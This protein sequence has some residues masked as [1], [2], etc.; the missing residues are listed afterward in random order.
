MEGRETLSARDVAGIR[1]RLETSFVGRC[2]GAFVVMQGVDRAMAIAAQAFTALIP[3][4]LL[5][6]ALA[7][8]DS[9]DIVSD[10]IIRR[11]ALG[12]AAAS[13]VR[14]LFAHAPDTGTGV[15]SVVLLVFSGVSLTRRIQGM[16]L[17]AWRL[18]ASG[19]LRTSANALLGLA[20]LM[21]EIALLYLARSLL[22][23]LPVDGLLGLPVSLLAGLFLWTSVPWLLLDRR[24]V[25][26]RLLP[27]GALAGL[28]SSI[29]GAASTISMP[30]LMESYSERFGLFGVTLALVGWLLS[31]ALIV[32]AATVV[33]A[34]FDRAPEPWAS[35]LR[36]RM[37]VESLD[38]SPADKGE[39]RQAG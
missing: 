21:V 4:L 19:G 17:R 1:R 8:T 34:E 10:A 16:Y 38:H 39:G 11:F 9:Q 29:Y 6:S 37:G 20:A 36:V 3:L 14:A 32:V 2:L 18:E 33:A 7:P 31:I 26:R 24:V 23:G 15:L 22:R 35:R 27:G 28:L 13:A 25:W 5:V 12:G 30:R